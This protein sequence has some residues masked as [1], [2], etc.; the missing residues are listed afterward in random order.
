[1]SSSNFEL[2]SRWRFRFECARGS[3]TVED[4]WDLPLS[5]ASGRPNL[6][7]IGRSLYANIRR[8]EGDSVSFVKSERDDDESRTQA[9]KHTQAKLE[10]VKYIIGVREAERAELQSARDRAAKRQELL[11]L[12]NEKENKAISDLP[13][14]KLREMV[15]A[16]K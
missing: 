7:D 11:A 4:L 13:V 16:L 9:L 1:M 6:N 5:D 3:I 15:A 2:A 14:E 12:I 8:L 10:L